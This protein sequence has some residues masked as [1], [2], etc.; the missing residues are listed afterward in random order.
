MAQLVLGAAGA[1]AGFFIG[2]PTGAQVGFALGSAVGAS[3]QKV[4]N[5]GA[6][7]SDLKAPQTSYGSVLPYVEGM[8]RLA[9]C[10]VWC[11][12]KREISTTTSGGGK[13][14][15]S[16]ENTQ[17]SYRMDALIL[18]SENPL[19]G[20]R[21]VWSNGKLVWSEAE[22]SEG[23]VG[24]SDAWE[25]LTFYSGAADQLPDPTYEA[26]V[27][28]GNAPAY[29]GRGSVFLEGIDLGGSGQPPALTFE[30]FSAGEAASTVDPE[31]ISLQL[32]CDGPGFV[33][34]SPYGKT[35]T[36]HGDAQVSTVEQV[37]G[38]GSLAMGGSGDYLT[39]AAHATNTL[40]GDFTIE[41]WVKLNAYASGDT[42][43]MGWSGSQYI[44]VSSATKL[45]NCVGFGS[46]NSYAPLPLSEW[47]HVSIN[48][49]GT[50]LKVFMGG[51]GDATNTST[52]NPGTGD[53]TMAIGSFALGGTANV[54]G[55][56]DEILVLNGMALR[57]EDF[58]P[59][60]YPRARPDEVPLADAIV[61]Q[62]QRAGLSSGQVDV[63][64][65]TGNVRGFAVT[66]ISAPRATLEM[67]CTAFQLEALE[68]GGKLR[69]RPRAQSSVATLPHD[70]L[71]ASEGEPVEPLPLVLANDLELPSEVVV[72]Y[73]NALADYQD[74][75]ESKP[76]RMG[77][78][79]SVEA[80]EL[81]LV[82]SPTEAR[83]IAEVRAADISA[84][85][86]RIERLQ[87]DRRYARLEPGDAI[88]IDDG[89][90]TAFRLRIGRIQDSG[91]IR[92]IEG[93]VDEQSAMT[94]AIDTDASYTEHLSVAPRAG[95]VLALL[96]IPLLRDVDDGLVH[97]LAVSK[98]SNAASWPGA[99]V[100]RGRGDAGYAQIATLTDRAYIGQTVGALSAF[101]GGAVFDER[102]QLQVTGVGELES[103]TRDQILA[104]QTPA[105]L[106]GSEVL[107][108]R[109]ATE[110]APGSYTL[111]GLLRGRR[112]TEWAISGHSSGERV[113]LLSQ[114]GLRVVSNT[115][116]EI[117]A[118]FDFKPVTNGTALD[119]A[120]RQAFVNTGVASKPFAPV[121]LRCANVGTGIQIGWA[122]RTRLR[123]SLAGAAGSVVPL[124]EAVE[125]YRVEVWSAGFGTV[126]RT[127]EALSSGWLYSNAEISADFGSIPPALFLRIA[128]IGAEG[129]VGR[130]AQAVLPVVAGAALP[131]GPPAESGAQA[132]RRS[133]ITA[134]G[135]E[136]LALRIEDTSP[137]Q[138]SYYQAASGG[139]L[140]PVSW[141][142]DPESVAFLVSSNNPLF[143]SLVDGASFRYFSDPGLSFSLYSASYPLDLSAEPVVYAPA[144]DLLCP[145]APAEDGGGGGPLRPQVA[146]SHAGVHYALAGS[147][148]GAVFLYSASTFPEWA[149]VGP[150]EYASG[151]TPSGTPWPIF[152]YEYPRRLLRSTGG[153]LLFCKAGVWHTS[154][155]VPRTGWRRIAALSQATLYGTPV[156]I[157]NRA[158]LVDGANVYVA[159]IP[160]YG[161]GRT[162]LASSADSGSTWTLH[163]IECR[164]GFEIQEGC[165]HIGKLGGEIVAIR[166]DGQRVYKAT[167]PSSGWVEHVTS[168]LETLAPELSH[169][170]SQ[171]HGRLWTLTTNDA[172]AQTYRIKTSADGVVWQDALYE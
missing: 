169:Q 10:W 102:S 128:Q 13:G 88:T 5:E 21:R 152:A 101:S 140:Q 40:D 71:G 91:Q 99:A 54:N 63:T 58:I 126:L 148:G 81:P 24:T 60:A 52:I 6:R 130:A 75:A 68:T 96:D 26:A 131:G 110:T 111:R 73:A 132:Y 138:A 65:V 113:V 90:G 98:S 8:V 32:S 127:H 103:W 12:N 77:V 45:I 156:S 86:Q 7:L 47:V 129:L 104:G 16:V 133:N 38:G 53:S 145:E 22:G 30:V 79:G 51:V 123:T 83:R 78:P 48:R 11:S 28:A 33:D 57:T 84:S 106:V 154:E 25:R 141:P 109:S 50:G 105:L 155:T 164:A 135:G 87:V 157:I 122:R 2:G 134:A 64:A 137:P 44:Y 37:A 85:V 74:G 82:L 146:A 17:F 153:W 19:G 143:L 49:A 4:R 172:G 3:T 108:Y 163:E 46:A 114:S 171:A 142:Y 121:N 35:I 118:S 70:D 120:T 119:A 100:Y 165:V 115:A 167:S 150:L 80:I 116:A 69:F 36:V 43:L 125:R 170:C 9:G 93:A 23:V 41:F 72:R 162:Y 42:Y 34:T 95:T 159:G 56:M 92:R 97:Y 76:R 136:L 149:Y 66:Q 166:A 55:W 144:S 20:I 168:G 112:G 151:E 14:G 161:A 139:V 158:I 94:G 67:L 27:G 31:F 15:P 29:R 18:L 89:H 59:S 147:G 117:G 124:G 62:C 1:V 107:L 39:V 61:R 160:G